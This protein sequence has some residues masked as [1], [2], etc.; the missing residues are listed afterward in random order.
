MT[1]ITPFLLASGD[2][3]AAGFGVLISLVATT[4]ITL[5]NFKV[6]RIFNE[7]FHCLRQSRAVFSGI[8]TLCF[9]QLYLQ[10]KINRL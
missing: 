5:L 10:Y 3:E 1:I 6:R 8:A 7:H 2:A 9:G 4:L